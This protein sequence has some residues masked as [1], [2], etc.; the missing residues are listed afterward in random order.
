[1]IYV[2]DRAVNASILPWWAGYFE[3]H[4]QSITV[5]GWARAVIFPA[6]ELAGMAMWLKSLIESGIDHKRVRMEFV[7]S[8]MQ[9]QLPAEASYV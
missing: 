3:R 4:A 9:R 7:Q 8:L 6:H 5:K 1:M 2:T